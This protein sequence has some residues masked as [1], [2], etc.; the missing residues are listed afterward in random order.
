MNEYLKLHQGV[1]CCNT[2]QRAHIYILFYFTD[3]LG[4]IWI[5]MLYGSFV[6]FELLFSKDDEVEERLTNMKIFLINAYK[7]L[8]D[9]GDV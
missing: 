6:N 2:S 1:K 8:S 9:Q 3:I 7:L 4:G 5:G